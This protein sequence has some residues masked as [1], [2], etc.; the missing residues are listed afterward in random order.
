MLEILITLIQILAI[1][2][3]GGIIVFSAL[4]A[5][6]ILAYSIKIIIKKLREQKE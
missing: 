3:L 5:L 6:F 2:I 4:V 1:I